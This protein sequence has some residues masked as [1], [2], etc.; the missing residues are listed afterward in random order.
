MHRWPT[1]STA[2]AADALLLA[3]GTELRTPTE[4]RRAWDEAT[5][6]G[7]RLDLDEGE[8][9]LLVE[10]VLAKVTWAVRGPAVEVLVWSLSG[11]REFADAV[12]ARDAPAAVAEGAARADCTEA[13]SV[14]LDVDRPTASS[15]P[16]GSP[17]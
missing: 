1:L 14:I 16:D 7:A 17:Q 9:D 4:L 13:A 2:W 6:S 11:G 3:A 5:A 15:P 12:R 10:V 8:R